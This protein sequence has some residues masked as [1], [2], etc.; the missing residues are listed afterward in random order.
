MYAVLGRASFEGDRLDEIVA[1][2]TSLIVPIM[3]A[4]AGHVNTYVCRSSDGTSGVAMSVFE[5]RAQV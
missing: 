4:Q 5:T 2:V 1:T 3:R